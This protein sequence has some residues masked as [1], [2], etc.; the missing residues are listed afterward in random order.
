MLFVTFLNPADY[1]QQRP[2][3]DEHEFAEFVGL[4]IAHPF[5]TILSEI[6]NY[7]NERQLALSFRRL[8]GGLADG[9][10]AVEVSCEKCF[11]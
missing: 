5:T 7:V 8:Q 6:G 9:A 10:V 1:Q 11:P 3:E 2:P 4:G